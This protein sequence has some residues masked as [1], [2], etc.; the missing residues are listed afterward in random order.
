MAHTEYCTMDEACELLGKT[1][2]EIKGMVADGRL[3]ELRDAGKIFFKREEVKRIAAK[4]G[5]SIVDLAAAEDMSP[6]IDGEGQPD[7]FA[8][9][10]SSLAD[11]SSSLGVLEANTPSPGVE[12]LMAKDP[13]PPLELDAE[14]FPQDLPAAAPPADEIEIPELSSEIDLLPTAEGSSIGLSPVVPEAKAPAGADLEVPDL[15]LSGSSI[16]SLE[17]TGLDDTGGP[18]KPAAKEP[19]KTGKVGISVFDDDE[20]KIDVDPMGET[21]ISAGAAEMETVGSGSGLLDLT[22]ES[23]D[24]SLGAALLDVISPTEAAETQTEGEAVEVIEAAETISESSGGTRTLTES[25]AEYVGPTAGMAPAMAA[26]SAVS[27]SMAGAVPMNIT[28]ILGIIS[29]ALIG[30]ATAAQLQGVWPATI[31]SPIAKDVVHW[32][33]FGGLAAIALGTGIWGILAGRK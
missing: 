18:A 16:I 19:A 28:P 10:L 24:T 3:H 29:L 22:Q 31:L 4:E 27:T 25:G 14:S 6:Q 13:S 9:A 33:V 17:T 7:S 20:L 11:E 32:A 8:S 5:S 23:D 2:T 15:G 1:D 30:L 21:R 12:E 26:R